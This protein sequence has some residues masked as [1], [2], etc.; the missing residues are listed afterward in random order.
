MSSLNQIDIQ[1]IDALLGSKSGYVL[2]FNN[3]D[4]EIFIKKTV[5]VNIFNLKYEA[6]GTSKG[7]RLKAF[8]EL[9]NDILSGRLLEAFVHYYTTKLEL[10]NSAIQSVSEKIVKDCLNLSFK[11]QG[12]KIEDPSKKNTDFLSMEVDETPLTTLNLPNSVIPILGERIIEIKKGLQHKMSLSVL[13]QAGSILEG[14]LLNIAT[15]SPSEFNQSPS[16]PKDKTGKVK[17]FHEWSLNSLIEVSY[18]LGYIGLDVKKHSHALRDFRNYIHPFEQM[19]SGFNP[20][21]HTAE[22]GWKVLKAAMHDLTKK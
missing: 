7:K 10:G 6:Y 2:D 13:F 8:W 3:Q 12:K 21:F 9:E 15:Q 18:E 14:L 22:I 16:A 20:D 11:L 19:A 4:F 5:N 1:K 17:A